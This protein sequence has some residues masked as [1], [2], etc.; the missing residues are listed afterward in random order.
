M[1][2]VGSVDAREVH[3]AASVTFP[4]QWKKSLRCCDETENVRI[5]R[6]APGFERLLAD[7]FGGIVDHDARVVDK[8]V[9]AAKF[10]TDNRR[11]APESVGGTHVNRDGARIK[12]FITQ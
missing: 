12:P 3:D 6:F 5:K 1:Q 9:E 11:S 10:L 4:E 7:L 8:N 2:R